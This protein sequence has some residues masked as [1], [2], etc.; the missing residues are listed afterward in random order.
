MVVC[1]SSSGAR[2]SSLDSM[3]LKVYPVGA[4]SLSASASCPEATAAHS[5]SSSRSD[6]TPCGICS[7]DGITLVSH[8]IT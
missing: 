4:E 3:N 6:T 2:G 1:G 5:Y 8:K 7:R